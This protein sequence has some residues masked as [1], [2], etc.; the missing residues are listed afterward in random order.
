MHTFSL[1]KLFSRKEWHQAEREKFEEMAG[2]RYGLVFGSAL[3]LVGWGWD[4]YE[5]WRA[6]SEIFWYK[7]VLVAIVIIPL[8]M[9]AGSVDGHAHRSITRKL[10]VWI[11][12]GG[13]TGFIA[14]FM[15]FEGTSALIALLDPT[16]RGI[17]LYPFSPGMQERIPLMTLFGAV[18]GLAAAAL[19]SLTT[20]WAWDSS[21]ADYRFTPQSWRLLFLCVPLSILLGALYDGSINSQVRAPFQI[22]HRLVQLALTTP[23]DADIHKM[24]LATMLNFVAVSTWRNNFSSHYTQH[25]VDLDRTKLTWAYVDV[26]FDNG[27]IWRC[28]SVRNGDDLTNCIDLQQKYRDWM[29]QFLRT[30]IVQCG[31]CMVTIPP[32]AQIWYTQ[33]ASRLGAPQ[34]ISITHHAGGVVIV[35]TTLANTQVD[36]RLVG[37]NPTIIHDC[38][39][40]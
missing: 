3:V 35:T 36:C 24:D 21:S 9:F 34:Q 8:T 10:I 1:D 39:S 16:V 31:D 37:A 12:I 13:A 18:V 7:L 28:Q 27:F 29:S 38:V 15:S 33:N 19:Q 22:S 23:P 40:R 6:S 4:A 20:S 26:E 14:S 5:L 11:L 17:T 25:L 32:P 30:G 2:W